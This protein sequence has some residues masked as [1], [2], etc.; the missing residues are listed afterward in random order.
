MTDTLTMATQVD[1]TTQE[2]KAKPKRQT[3]KSGVLIDRIK[4]AGFKVYVKHMRQTTQGEFTRKQRPAE[5][6][7]LPTGGSTYITIED[8]VKQFKGESHCHPFD[9]YDKNLGRFRALGRAL[10]A[11]K[12]TDPE[13][14]TE[15]CNIINKK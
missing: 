3:N 1:T 2:Q 6:V 8:G 13:T 9:N 15:I 5:A 12:Y 4:A 10:N 14:H 11:M 7:V